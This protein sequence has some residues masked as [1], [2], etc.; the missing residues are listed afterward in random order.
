M[1]GEGMY[2]TVK[3]CVKA[4]SVMVKTMMTERKS[5][6]RWVK[7]VKEGNLRGEVNKT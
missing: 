4:V 1:I 2:P 3:I 6:R 5:A 7:K